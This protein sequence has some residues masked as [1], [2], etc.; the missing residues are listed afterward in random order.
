LASASSATVDVDDQAPG[1]YTYD[2]IGN[3][4][5]DAQEGTTITWTP[6]G[7][8]KTVVKSGSPAS[9]TTFVYDA[10]GNR[11][12][13]KRDNGAGVVITNYYVRDAS[14]NIMAVYEKQEQS[15]T[16][17]DTKLIEVPIYGSDR[18]GLYKGLVSITGT[19]ETLLP[20]EER[21]SANTEKNAY[22][23]SSYLVDNGATL[24]LGDG[25]VFEAGVMGAA[26]SVRVSADLAVPG[27]TNGM[28]TRALGKRQYELK[29][30]LGNVRTVITDVKK[31][32]LVSG[33]PKNFE[34]EIVSAHNYYPFGMDMPGMTAGNKYRYGFNGKEKD[35]NGEW[36]NTAYD[37]GFRIY[38]PSI[39][40]FLSVDP[41]MKSYPM[42]T[43]YQFA[44]NRPIDGVDLDGLEYLSW[45]ALNFKVLTGEA[46][47]GPFSLTFNG[48]NL[49][50][51]YSAMNQ[52][53]EFS[54][55]YSN[56]NR[57]SS[58][59]S[60][61][62]E[63]V[64]SSS[65]KVEIFYP[66]KGY[67]VEGGKRVVTE[68]TKFKSYKNKRFALYNREVSAGR[69]FGQ[70]AFVEVM[71]LAF[72][73]YLDAKKNQALSEFRAFQGRDLAAA[74]KTLDLLLMSGSRNLIPN[75]IWNSYERMSDLANLIL[76]EESNTQDFDL[77]RLFIFLFDN[78]GFIRTGEGKID[79]KH[80]LKDRKG[81]WKE[82]Y[83]GRE[84]D[85]IE[86]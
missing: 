41:L 40:K 2:A 34:P 31:S 9:A 69:A 73:F 32:T 46:N 68:D 23:E 28:F 38:N 11:V 16:T 78:E 13:K 71:L 53:L 37:Y 15:G 57:N 30:H 36:G 76:S 43:P 45:S 5:G 50:N 66:S 29:D 55:I 49:N 86:E 14:G 77:Y 51:Y 39:G 72:D 54:G 79:G 21:I 70:G 44:S 4:T 26:F 42:L 67:K 59:R 63:V 12:M 47:L 27:E 3:L 60:F 58:E 61:Y 19:T 81:D 24:T 84:V 25:F 17:P 74:N 33:V 83:S 75:E 80:P 64:F 1:N 52:G 82:G 10:A 6:Y 35:D 85:F 18:L 56:P 7:K 48:T 22:E 62:H 8:V 65:G 20:G